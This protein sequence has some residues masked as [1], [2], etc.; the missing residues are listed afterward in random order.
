MD[1]LYLELTSN[2]TLPA[3][4]ANGQLLFIKNNTPSTVTLTKGYTGGLF[5]TYSAANA[6]SLQVLP[7]GHIA[8]VGYVQV[9]NVGWIA[10]VSLDP[11]YTPDN[12]WNVKGNTGTTPANNYIGTTDN[13]D[14]VV[15]TNNTEKMRVQAGGNVG[16]GTNA[17][18]STLNV[19][20]SG[21]GG[22]VVSTTN[23][24]N[25]VLRME[26]PA[27]GQSV[28]Q[29]L[30]AKN[31]SGTAVSVA[32]GINPNVGTNGVLLFSKS[33]SGDFI[34]DLAN[35]NI[36]INTTPTSK[37]HVNGNFRLVD[38]TQAANRVLTTDANGNASWKDLPVSNSTTAFTGP[39][40]AAAG[41]TNLVWNNDTGWVNNVSTDV[42]LNEISDPNNVYDPTTGVVTI[43][44][45]GAYFVTVGARLRNNPPA[46]GAGFDGTA[47]G[48]YSFLMIKPN[49]SGSFTQL[50]S[51]ALNVVRG[52]NNPGGNVYYDSSTETVLLLNVGDQ[53]KLN[54]R[55]YGTANMNTNAS[56][57]VLEKGGCYLNMYKF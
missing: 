4:N 20:S 49:G 50:A 40:V 28:I 33:N 22:N 2:T 42:P 8:F 35:G 18:A 45:A 25:T 57:V 7:L 16:I 5:D 14:F 51:Q 38:G 12:Y 6:T 30:T 26:N 39:Y 23:T 46:I 13:Q 54:F 55:T 21:T 41:G 37:L 1:N 44:T 48:F 52:L 47:G 11:S 27:N 53:I 32:M 36:G 10:Q 19:V 17:P 9:G 56:N 29:N 3:P 24:A 31:P 34:M 15:R 43:T